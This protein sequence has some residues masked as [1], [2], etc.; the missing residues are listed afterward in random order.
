MTEDIS[1]FTK[2]EQTRYTFYDRG[3][4]IITEKIELSCAYIAELKDVESHYIKS[5]RGLLFDP[6]GMDANKLNAIATKFSK[7][8]KETFDFYIDYLKT[9][10]KNYYAWAERSNVDV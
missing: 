7:V 5:L 4:N 2:A 8:K 10:E 9:K 3:G 6:Q 1:E